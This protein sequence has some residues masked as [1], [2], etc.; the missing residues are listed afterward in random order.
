MTPIRFGC[1][2]L[3]TQSGELRRNGKKI[4]LQEQPFQVLTLLLERPGEVLTREELTKR[5][6]P[7]E[8]YVDFDR[9]LN[10]AV[11]RLRDALGD[12]AENPRYIET[13]PRRG[14]R[15][16]ASIAS[17]AAPAANGTSVGAIAPVDGVETQPEKVPI[18]ERRNR[19]RHIALLAGLIAVLLIVGSVVSWR[20]S[21]GTARVAKVVRFRQLTNDGQAKMGPL[22]VD[23]PRVYF[24]ELLPG[25]RKMVFQVSIR[26]GEATPL[27]FQLKQPA[28]LDASEDGT[29]LLLTDTE[30]D[31]ESLWIQTVASGSPRRVGTVLAHDAAFG[32]GANNIIYGRGTDV[33]SINPDGSGVRKVLNAGHV[34]FA[35]QYSP[36][37]RAFRFSVFD[38]QMDEMLILESTADGSKFRKVF[39]GCCG[40]WTTD[41]R[42]FIF[43][44]RRD[45]RLDFWTLPVR[46]AFPWGTGSDKPTQLT[47]GPLDYQF[48]LPSKDGK[49]VFALGTSH[50]AELIRYD[51]HSR[52]FIPF[53]AGISAEGV[54]FS[55]DG[56]W[57]AYTSFPEGELWRSK[58]DGSERRQLTFRPLRAFLPRWSPDGRQIAFSA[59]VTGAKRSVFLISSEGGAPRR[60]LASEQSQSDV[61]WSPDGNRLVFGSLFVPNAP[62]YIFDLRTQSVTAVKGSEGFHSPRWSPDGS[63]IAAMANG[64]LGKLMLF[65][66]AKEKWVEAVSFP[67]GYPTWSHDGKYIYFQYSNNEEQQSLRESIGRIRLADAK[68]E[69]V[70]DLKD[71]GRVTTGTF[72]EWFGLAPDDSPLFARDAS[73]QEIYAI[74]VEW[75]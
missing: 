1:F 27:A 49:T 62:I 7:D 5:L 8:T 15:F 52:Q 67:V 29:E 38:L 53:L 68:I 25:L 21:V 26:G 34:P 3:D 66:I 22:V 59:D 20:W 65:D 41:G 61:N 56:Q 12:S 48:P 47:A 32:P 69:N 51:F 4:K 33:Y 75:P 2:E 23:G 42:H 16:I 72:V 37:A 28:I 31:G 9:G 11:T 44:S 54:T 35:F 45:G 30:T 71:V 74:D 6:W 58:I 17:S 19:S 60:V 10:K 18:P 24:N 70:V 40:R 36:D 64:D 73:T 50:R 39:N 46:K 55:R 43:Q 13:L 63:V 57:V 14:Y